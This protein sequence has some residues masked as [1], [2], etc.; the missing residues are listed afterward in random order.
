MIQA[1]DFLQEGMHHENHKN[2]QNL[3]KLWIFIKNRDFSKNFK[4]TAS[5]RL[6]NL[7]MLSGRAF[8]F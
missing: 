2:Q 8:L 1:F 5:D 3:E 7:L 4:L 6:G